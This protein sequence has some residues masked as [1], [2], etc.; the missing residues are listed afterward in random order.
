MTYWILLITPPPPPPLPLC[1]SRITKWPSFALPWSY[2]AGEWIFNVREADPSRWP[3]KYSKKK[4]EQNTASIFQPASALVCMYVSLQSGNPT[5]GGLSICTHRFKHPCAQIQAPN[6][7]LYELLRHVYSGSFEH[8][9]LE[10]LSRGAGHIVTFSWDWR[11]QI[12]DE[13]QMS[14]QMRMCLMQRERASGMSV[15]SW[16][17]CA[18]INTLMNTFSHASRLALWMKRLAV[19]LLNHFV[20]DWAIGLIAF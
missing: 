4:W 19:W 13:W 1:F 15:L 18:C 20:P 11:A 8:R 3:L 2:S 12:E 6:K 10:D 14:M 17:H 7:H 5:Q 16:S 9:D